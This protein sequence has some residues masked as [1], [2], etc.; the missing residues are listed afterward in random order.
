MTDELELIISVVSFIFG[1]AVFIFIKEQH[2]TAGFAAI[3]LA[4]IF[5][6][7]I[8]VLF[9]ESFL[10]FY[11]WLRS[12]DEITFNLLLLFPII[13]IFIILIF[14]TVRL[15]KMSVQLRRLIQ[16]TSINNLENKESKSN[17]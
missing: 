3:W 1:I 16:L 6:A 4:G 15:S 14:F 9:G 8:T 12:A 2:L 10:F 17:D 13:Y 5:F 7:V 11:A